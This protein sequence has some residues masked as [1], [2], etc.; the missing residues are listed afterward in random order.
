M[1]R[2]LWA[3]AIAVLLILFDRMMRMDEER[4]CQND[5]TAFAECAL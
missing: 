2:Y 1:K 5:E 4:L 3:I